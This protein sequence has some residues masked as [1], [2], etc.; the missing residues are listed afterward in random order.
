MLVAHIGSKLWEV[1]RLVEQGVRQ[2]WAGRL[3]YGQARED[4]IEQGARTLARSVAV[5]YRLLLEGIVAYLLKEGPAG[6]AK[7]VNNLKGSQF[8]R[9]LNLHK[10]ADWLNG[11]WS[12]LLKN[13]KLQPK[14]APPSTPSGPAAPKPAPKPPDAGPK[15]SS[16]TK[17]TKAETLKKNRE[18]GK[19][20]ETEVTDE[21][22][23]EGH[24]VLGTQVTV[25]TSQ[26]R[27]VLDNL[28]QK[29]GETGLTNVEVKSGNATRSKLQISKD[30][31]MATVGGKI[32]GKNAPPHLRGQTVKIKTEVRK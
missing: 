17:S 12:N 26:T 5:F 29:K 19:K 2:A 15:P 31:E 7:I 23:A 22:K 4:A 10:F 13:P 6:V 32:V 20:R 8:A 3:V 9:F 16:S 27:R 1:N 14:Q 18:N 30:N 11:N 28:A 24:E 21:L 25:K